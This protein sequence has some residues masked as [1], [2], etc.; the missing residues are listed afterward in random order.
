MIV[1]EGRH[2]CNWFWSFLGFTWKKE[3]NYNLT[4]IE[5]W[6]YKYRNYDDFDTSKILRIS[7]N[8]HHYQDSVGLGINKKD[9]DSLWF[10]TIVHRGG[11]IFTEEIC[12]AKMGETYKIQIAIH[13]DSYSVGVNNKIINIERTSKYWGPRYLIGLMSGGNNVAPNTLK[14]QLTQIIYL[15]YED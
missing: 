4:L 5:G 14:V 10:R 13:K 7:D 15:L 1:K 11:E 9:D 6:E 2:Y 3:K 8:L 12:Q